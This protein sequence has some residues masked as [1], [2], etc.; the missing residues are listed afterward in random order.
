ME[1]QVEETPLSLSQESDATLINRTHLGNQR[2][3]ESLVCRYSPILLNFVRKRTRSG[4]QTEDIVQVVLLQC[5]LSLPSLYLYLSSR[6]SEL[7]L[8]P[9]LLRVAANRC[10]D[11]ARRKH[12]L[13][14]SEVPPIWFDA[15]EQQEDYVP[16]ESFID[17][18]PLP[19]ETAE[20]QDLQ[21]TLRTAINALPLRFSRIVLLR[22][23]EELTFKE[24]GQRLRMPENTVRTYFHRALPLL[25]ASLATCA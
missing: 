4:E 24:I 17:P 3:F 18:S 14:F 15:G 8:R 6:H 12:P 11:E 7:P 2:A 25:R 5:Y 10:I 22:Y 16:E 1:T 21:E 13:Y 9:W 19:E 23:T 20:L